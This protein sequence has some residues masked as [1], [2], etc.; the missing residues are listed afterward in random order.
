MAEMPEQ[1]EGFDWQGATIRPLRTWWGDLTGAFRGY[2]PSKLRADAVAGLTVAVV[3]VPQ[4]MAYAI[5][6]GVPAVYGIYTVI[7]Q[8]VIGAVFN[9]HPLLSVGPINTQSLLVASIVTRLAGGD[10]GQFLALVISLTLLKGLMQIGMAAM[11]LGTLVRYVSQSVIVGFT[12]GAGVLIAAGQVPALL[13][14]GT[15]RTAEQ[16][17]GLIG[18]GQRLWPELDRVAWQSVLLGV[19]ALVL[20]LGA[21][22]LHRHAPGPLL[23]VGITALATWLL[24]WESLFRVVGALPRG[25]PAPALPDFN[26]A[27]IEMLAGGA[28]ALSLLGLMEAY[29]IGK[30]LAART[31]HRV[32]ANRE[33]MSQGITNAATSFL[34]CIPG[35]G[36]FS[37]SALNQYAGGKTLL[38]NFFNSAFVLVIFLLFADAAAY[39]PMAAIAAIL[40]VIAYGLIDWRYFR[41]LMGSNN[42]DAAVCLGTFLST[43]LAPLAY[44]VFIGIALNFALYLRRAKQV[45]IT[46]MVETGGPG[47]TGRFTER[48][49]RHAA[50]DRQVMFLQLEGNLF[51]ATADELQDHFIDLLAGDAEVIVLRL[52]R[53]HLVDATVMTTMIRFAQQLREQGR[54]LLL[55]G[56][57]PRMA[58]RFEQ[59]GLTDVIGQDHIFV[60]DTGVFSSAKAALAKARQITGQPPRPDRD[61]PDT[62]QNWAYAI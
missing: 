59:F 36:S 34:S 4:S 60:S 51:F 11:H 26:W 35:S 20:V 54:H 38:S 49:V 45:H 16:W 24:D 27:T 21:R 1:H 42:A 40:F 57:R 22:K 18:I 12:A 37:R 48:P 31:G 58:E 2:N 23:A 56:V 41:R 13:G 53:T 47:T 9:S 19:I 50:P 10:E 7:F 62:P 30:T 28:L 17:P 33:L 8:C 43:L 25:L 5:I 6:A 3:A 61:A 14:F 44:A 52:K 55:C 46:E 29:S 32:S 39:I 15:T